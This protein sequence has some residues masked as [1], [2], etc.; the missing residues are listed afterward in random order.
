MTT[1]R[2]ALVDGLDRRE[3]ILAA[4]EYKFA[5]DGYH[6]TTMR[7]IAAEAD[8]QLS[9]LVY[10]FKT[11]LDLYREIFVR[12]QYV[13]E[14]RIKALDAI[15]DLSAEGALE[16]IVSAFADPVLALHTDPRGL[17][18]A[19]LALREASDP[20]SH[21]RGIIQEFFDP[22]GRTFI[23][24]L[25]EAVPGRPSNFYPRAYLFAVAVLTQSSLDIRIQD[26]SP[27]V[28]VEANYALIRQFIKAGWAIPWTP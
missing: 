25:E 11:K 12:R 6:G 19:R 13:N 28:D 9:L 5:V 1:G 17:W 20:S 14:A 23:A 26:L 10:H 3:K 16:A 18:F 15:G 8:V 2:T 7:G 4:A 24:A 21:E 27:S 22:M